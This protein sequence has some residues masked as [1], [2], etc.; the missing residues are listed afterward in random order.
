MAFQVIIP[1][2]KL[3][4]EIKCRILPIFTSISA[5]SLYE[6]K[7]NGLTTGR[8]RKPDESVKHAIVMIV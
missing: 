3:V 2:E 7:Q 1:T 8:P 4:L 6:A 5:K